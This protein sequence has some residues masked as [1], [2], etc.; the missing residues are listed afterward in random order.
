M[1]LKIDNSKQ[2]KVHRFKLFIKLIVILNLCLSLN[3][4]SQNGMSVNTTGL[5][6]DASAILDVSSTS[7][8]LLIP[9]MTTVQ[10]DK[11]SS[12]VLSLLIFNTTTNCFEAYVNGTWYSVSCPPPC[13]LP[14]APAT[15]TNISSQTQ[16]TWIWNSVNGASGYKWSTANNNSNAADNGIS[17]SY[18]QTGLTCNTSHTLYVWAYNSCGVSATS[19]ALSQT[20]SACPSTVVTYTYSSGCAPQTWTVPSGVY[21]LYVTVSGARGGI[22]C[23]YGGIGGDGVTIQDILSVS[24]G[25]TLYL[26]IGGQGEDNNS[27]GYPGAGGCNGGGIGAGDVLGWSY[28]GGG[29]GG[30]SDIRIGGQ[31]LSNRVVVAAGGG[32]GGSYS[33]QDGGAG[34]FTVGTNGS[35][36]TGSCSTGFGGDIPG[37]GGLGG[38]QS[39]GGA[40][41]TAGAITNLNLYFTP[42]QPGTLGNG[43]DSGEDG[44]GGGGGGYYGGGGGGGGYHGQQN[45]PLH[46]GGCA[47]GGGGSSYS[48]SG[49]GTL[50]GYNS[51]NGQILISY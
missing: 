13:S 28:G 16:I 25:Q 4:F 2:S 47:G 36:C 35:T 17:T 48:Q 50:T 42:G 33:G 40:G 18:T 43:G 34:G 27:Y 9:R 3:L 8:G 44:G 22:G 19:K 30:A 1:H 10:R 41:G 23:Y 45:G 20:T 6:A 24:P 14:L 15:G 11:I 26:Y 32:G 46:T 49:S 12:P 7:Q 21:T 29:G 39:A 5:P 31:A 37:G 51:G 38:T